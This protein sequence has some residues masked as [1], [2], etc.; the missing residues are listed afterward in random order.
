MQDLELREFLQIIRQAEMADAIRAVWNAFLA[1]VDDSTTSS[2]S[3]S[4]ADASDLAEIYARRHDLFRSGGWAMPGAEETVDALAREHGKVRLGTIDT[5]QHYGIAFIS[6]DLDRV[7][8]F[9][10]V[11]RDPA[12]VLDE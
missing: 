9:L 2:L 3:D 10:F 6:P 5:R 4:L 7:V 11:D 8:G 12:Q 1:N